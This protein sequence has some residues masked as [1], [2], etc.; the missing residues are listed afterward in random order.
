MSEYLELLDNFEALGLMNM[1]EY[2]PEILH[3]SSEKELSLTSM[4]IDLTNRELAF[5]DKK[6]LDRALMR[7]RFPA[8]KT[9][10][11]FDFSFQPSIKPTEILEL[12]HLGFMEFQENIIFIGNP[13][14]GKTHLAISVGVCACHQGKRTLFITCHELL[15][16]L[17]SANKKGTLER[18]LQRY[19]RYE[20]LIIDEIGYL[21]IEKDEAYLLFQLLN[22]R[23]EKH[24]TLFSTNVPLSSWG[25]LFKSPET[26]VAILDRLV[27]H[28]RIFRITGKSYR[29]INKIP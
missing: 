5:Q 7:A 2:Y 26:A 22:M 10:D 29:M 21:P 16:R 1:R 19:A 20:L 3:M 24:S 23:Y 4:L 27:H 9:F 12:Q 11:S 15:L 17:S 13:G 8:I 18:V 6:K 14:V 28:S 25:E